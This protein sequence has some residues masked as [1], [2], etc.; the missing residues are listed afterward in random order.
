MRIVLIALAP[1]LWAC[2]KSKDADSVLS[3]SRTAERQFEEAMDEFDDEDCVSAEKLFQD[4]IKK[5]PYSRYAVVAELRI[6][7][8]QFVQGNHAEAAVSYQQFVKAHPT[9]EETHY[10]SFRKALSYYEMI[11]GD[12]IITPPPYERDQSATR[13]ARGAFASFIETYP[14]S[15]FRE[16]AIALLGEVEDALVRHE[17]Y[18]A[19][20]YLTRGDRRAASM[21]LEGIWKNYRQ[22]KLTPDAMFMQAVTLAEM[23]K[24]DEARR[25]LAEIIDNYPKHHQSLRAR[26]FLKHLDRK[27]KGA[28]RGD[29]G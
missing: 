2:N 5:F 19:E 8:C 1:L 9:H 29:D 20:F 11:P 10:A 26:D 25:V 27:T 18:V 17:M 28:D 22:S 4:V 13:D 3:Y 23:N 7:D 21:R 6:A 12:W 15:P 14:R 16:R 24:T